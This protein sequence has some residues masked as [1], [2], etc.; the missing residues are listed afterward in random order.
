[1]DANPLV[2]DINEAAHALRMSRARLYQ[3]LSDGSIPSLKIGR[4]RR[5]R[6]EALVAFLDSLEGTR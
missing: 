1:M 2:Y 3:L 5:I 6:R 4:S